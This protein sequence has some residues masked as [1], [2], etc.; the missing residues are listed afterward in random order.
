MISIK[1]K[2][3]DRF[4]TVLVFAFLGIAFLENG[5]KIFLWR[6]NGST[7]HYALQGIWN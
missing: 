7:K 4:G 5:R 2:Y 1:K 3:L 6:Q